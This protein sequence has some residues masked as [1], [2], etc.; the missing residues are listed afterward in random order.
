MQ[1]EAWI[2]PFKWGLHWPGFK[3]DSNANYHI[4]QLGNRFGRFPL[5]AAHRAPGQEGK[6]F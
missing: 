6:T 5:D 2:S 3:R 1:L 4:P